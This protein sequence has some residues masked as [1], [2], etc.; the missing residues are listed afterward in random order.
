MKSFKLIIKNGLKS[1]LMKLKNKSLKNYTGVNQI[2]SLMARGLVCITERI[3]SVKMAPQLDIYLTTE[4]S[5]QMLQPE[6]Y[7][8]MF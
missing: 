2:G 6:I 3:K 5:K 7:Q 1:S 8:Q 4:Q